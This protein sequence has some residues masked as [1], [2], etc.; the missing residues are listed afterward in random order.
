MELRLNPAAYR[1]TRHSMSG[2]WSDNVRVGLIQQRRPAL[3]GGGRAR[4]I[5]PCAPLPGSSRV[6]GPH[7]RRSC[8]PPRSKSPSKAFRGCRWLELRRNALQQTLGQ[9]DL[10]FPLPERRLGRRGQFVQVMIGTDARPGRLLAQALAALVRGNEARGS[11]L[12]KL[13]F[14]SYS[15]LGISRTRIANTSCTRSAASASCKPVRSA[16]WNSRGE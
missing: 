11:Q 4:G 1:T 8:H 5:W 13:L 10:K 2:T 14:E 9:H 7:R 12:R 15:K 16:Q 3:S 6:R